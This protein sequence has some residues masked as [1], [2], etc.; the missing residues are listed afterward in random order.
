MFTRISNTI[1][2]VKLN[3]YS[4]KGSNTEIIGVTSSETLHRVA[5][6]TLIDFRVFSQ[7]RGLPTNLFFACGACSITL[8][9]EVLCAF[10]M[11]LHFNQTTGRHILDENAVRSHRPE[12]LR[13]DE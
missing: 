10:E 5:L 2:H 13:S 6:W 12:K 3:R 7:F 4:M 8:M 9:M 1:K 11:S